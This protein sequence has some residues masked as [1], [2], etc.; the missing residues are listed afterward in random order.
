MAEYQESPGILADELDRLTVRLYTVRDGVSR[1]SEIAW[2]LENHLGKSN[3][4]VPK[5]PYL[6]ELF[7]FIVESSVFSGEPVLHPVRMAKT[8][9]LLR[10][11]S[12]IFPK[13]LQKELNAALVRVDIEI[14]LAE[15]NVGSTQYAR[16]VLGIPEGSLPTEGNG[17]EQLKALLRVHEPKLHQALSSRLERHQLPRTL[18]PTRGY[19]PVVLSWTSRDSIAQWSV[20][21]RLV[22]TTCLIERT[23]RDEDEL[24]VS[25]LISDREP[26]R[27]KE[28][29]QPVLSSG[30]ILLEHLLPGATK[31]T[32]SGEFDCSAEAVYLEGSSQRALLALLFAIEA[33]RFLDSRIRYSVSSE[34]VVTGDVNSQGVLLPVDANTLA[35]KV[36]AAFFFGATYLVVPSGNGELA[37][38]TL[39]NLKAQYPQSKLSI[40]S[41]DSLF[42]LLA[43]RRIVKADRKALPLHV[44]HKMWKRRTEIAPVLSLAILVVAYALLGPGSIDPHIQKIGF[45]NE[46]ELV[47]KNAEGER[48]HSV[49]VGSQTYR[50]MTDRGGRMVEIR[51]LNGDGFNDPVWVLDQNL[52]VGINGSVTALDGATLD[53]LFFFKPVFDL[54]YPNDISIVHGNM[55]AKDLA[56]FDRD[57]D[58]L[59]EL[60]ISFEH[61][62][63][64]PSIIA[65]IDPLTGIIEQRYDHPGALREM[66]VT[67]MNGDG[68][69]E[70]VASG[71]NNSMRAGVFLVLDP[72]D[73]SDSGPAEKKQYEPLPTRVGKELLYYVLPRSPINKHNPVADPM[74]SLI[75]VQ[76]NGNLAVATTDVYV[77]NEDNTTAA[78]SYRMILDENYQ[79]ISVGTSSLWDKGY[80]EANEAGLVPAEFSNEMKLEM[81]KAVRRIK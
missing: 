5:A 15:S 68:K 61:S 29:L 50:L 72:N 37:R 53:T 6:L 44:I 9:Q 49:H 14:M 27:V 51:D 62:E 32:F 13:G 78:A 23:T 1:L 63:Y 35:V 80:K 8:A 42:D 25:S 17:L 18:G 74:A 36:E 67:D 19:Y 59:P 4:S 38:A 45:E 24:D 60:F 81:L 47:F 76:P 43:D 30:R 11:W 69:S 41:R 65:A 10:V 26:G 12:N 16:S 54:N 73:F 7:D 77:L 48:V 75:S 46:S 31:R 64:Y 56:V 3:P 21:G 2:F 71:T 33:S 79:P 70:I 57:G 52:E 20:Q 66:F 40:I 58:D 28:W 39:G 55:V 22:T 34:C